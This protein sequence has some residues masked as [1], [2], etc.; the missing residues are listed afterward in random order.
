MQRRLCT[1]CAKTKYLLLTYN[2]I[3]NRGTSKCKTL[4]CTNN[5]FKQTVARCGR[6][7]GPRN[8]RRKCGLC[9]WVDKLRL[10]NLNNCGKFSKKQ[11][12]RNTESSVQD[13]ESDSS[14]GDNNDDDQEAQTAAGALQ[15]LAE[16]EW[17]EEQVVKPVVAGVVVATNLVHEDDLYW[18]KKIEEL[19]KKKQREQEIRMQRAKFE[20]ETR[21]QQAKFEEETRKQQAKFEEET[22]KQR[23]KLEEEARKQQA[24]FAA[25]LQQLRSSD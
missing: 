2:Q 23:A 16:A 22:R 9:L 5:T 24:N 6:K 20:E 11:A 4:N 21:K 25:K 8:P 15:L 1:A 14:Q 7:T 12:P 13:T 19:T 17:R 10:D 18:D 3:D